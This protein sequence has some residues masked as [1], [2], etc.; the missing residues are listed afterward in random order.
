MRFFLRGAVAHEARGDEIAPLGGASQ[1]AKRA[2]S[3]LT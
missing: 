3:F 2:R 1:R